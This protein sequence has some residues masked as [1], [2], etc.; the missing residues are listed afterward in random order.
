MNLMAKNI[1]S[2]LKRCKGKLKEA[3]EQKQS[4]K[5]KRATKK[6]K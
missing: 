2:V 3:I 6:Q 4:R 1:G 5:Q